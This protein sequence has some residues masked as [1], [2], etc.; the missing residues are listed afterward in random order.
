M[1]NA[2]RGPFLAFLAMAARHALIRVNA[3]AMDQA[4]PGGLRGRSICMGCCFPFCSR[5]VPPPLHRH[6][7]AGMG[8]SLSHGSWQEPAR[9]Q[10]RRRMNPISHG[11]EV[12]SLT[13]PDSERCGQLFHPQPECFPVMANGMAQNIQRGHHAQTGQ[14]DAPSRSFFPSPEGRVRDFEHRVRHERAIRR[15]CQLLRHR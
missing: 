15:A 1:H 11:T 10:F 2:A 5:A 14:T 9:V 6:G 13:I 8:Q 12:R 4:M 3:R 7:Q